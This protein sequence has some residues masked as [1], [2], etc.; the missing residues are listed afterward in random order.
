MTTAFGELE[1]SQTLIQVSQPAHISEFHF[2]TPSTMERALTGHASMHFPQLKH[3]F[4]V[5]GLWQ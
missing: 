2:T 3:L 5:S 1:R 4:M